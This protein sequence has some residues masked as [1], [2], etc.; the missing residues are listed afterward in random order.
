MSEH[1]HHEHHHHDHPHGV[2]WNEAAAATRHCLT[3]CGIGE[4]LG[5]VIGNIFNWHG[6]VTVVISIALAFLFGYAL[7][8]T[9]VLKAGVPF[10]QAMRVALAADTVSI[11]CM[12][13]IDNLT[14]IV[15]PGAMNAGL[16]SALF[17]ITLFA[18]L[19]IAFLLTTPVNKWMIG[20]GKGHAVVHAYHH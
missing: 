17:W 13:I 12:E 16:S 11:I 14:V 7:T 5:M 10:K 6:A 4:V 20:Q 3:G 15:V 9:P 1:E 2:S 18:G 8:I 19:G